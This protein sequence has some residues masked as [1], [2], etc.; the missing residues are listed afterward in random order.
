MSA[1]KKLTESATYPSQVSEKAF[2]VRGWVDDYGR[3][4]AA[5]GNRA[6]GLSN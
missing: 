1:G 5:G 2:Q 4:R 3:R 6:R